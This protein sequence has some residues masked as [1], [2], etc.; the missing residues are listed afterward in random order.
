[1]AADSQICELT[2]VNQSD[3]N[4]SPSY[5]HVPTQTH[6]ATHNK[7]NLQT[8]VI[9]QTSGSALQLHTVRHLDGRTGWSGG[10]QGTEAGRPHGLQP[11][12]LEEAQGPGLGG[13]AAAAPLPLL[14]ARRTDN[15][16]R[17]D[18]HSK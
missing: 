18:N 16:Q 8:S 4:F 3:V 9:P 15:P 1:M 17:G 14:S 13:R 6:M 7:E 11:G 12:L 2:A 5:A 10:A